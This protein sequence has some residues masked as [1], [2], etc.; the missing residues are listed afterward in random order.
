[1]RFSNRELRRMMKKAGVV[2]EEVKDVS[3]VDIIL[4][5]GTILRVNNPIVAKMKVSGQVTFQITGE[6]EV[7]EEER[8]IEISEEDLEIVMSQTGVDKELAQKA[9]EMTEGDIAQAILLLKEAK[10]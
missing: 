8:E 6:E 1:M 3:R 10:L 2:F 5:D 9:L 7:V 4:N